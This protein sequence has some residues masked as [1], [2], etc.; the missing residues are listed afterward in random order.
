M[1]DLS[2]YVYNAQQLCMCIADLLYVAPVIN[3]AT[4]DGI[5]ESEDT[6]LVQGLVPNVDARPRFATMSPR[7]GGEDCSRAVVARKACLTHPGAIVNDNGC[8]KVHLIALSA[9]VG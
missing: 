2:L 7:D 9:A 5:L 1:K 8:R 3:N 4:S 6:P